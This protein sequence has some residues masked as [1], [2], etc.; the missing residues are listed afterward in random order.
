MRLNVN[1]NIENNDNFCFIRSILACFHP[2]NND[3]LDRFSNYRKYFIELN[4]QGF[5]F[6]NGFR[7]S[8]SHCFQ[9][10]NKLSIN[11][12]ELIFYQDQK[13][14]K[15]SLIPIEI[16]NDES[17]RVVDLLIYENHYALKN[18]VNVFLGDHNKNFICR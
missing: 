12:F 5:N 11:I 8:A 16:N 15:C 18:K 7:C 4:V 13:K 1:L 9:L 17:D 10:L 3:H 14:R 6:I 2:C